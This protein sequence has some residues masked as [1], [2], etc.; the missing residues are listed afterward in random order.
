MDHLADLKTMVETK[1]IA[2]NGI[3]TLDS[4]NDRI[5]VGCLSPKSELA[6]SS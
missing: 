5:K 1:K 2:G 3:L 4:Y 6:S